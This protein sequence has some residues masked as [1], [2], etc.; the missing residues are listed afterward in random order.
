MKK[1]IF[2]STMA[3]LLAVSVAGVMK[4]SAGSEHNVMGWLWGGGT[5]S[6][7]VE[8]W[9]GTHT[10]LGWISMNSANPN[11]S[12]PFN[13]GVNIFESGSY[14]DGYAWSSNI[15]WVDFAPQSH[16]T[17]GSPSSGQYKAASC[18][19]DSGTAGVLRSGDTLTGWARFVSIA[20]A[21][22]DGNSGGWKGWIKMSGT[23]DDGSPYGITINNAGDGFC[24]AGDLTTVEIGGENHCFAWSDELGWIDFS[25][26]SIVVPPPTNNLK[27]CAGS[28]NSESSP[29]TVL[30]MN[31]NSVRDDLRACYNTETECVD[32]S[33]TADVTGSATWE[34]SSSVI[35]LTYV[36]PNEELSAGEVSANSSENFSVGYLTGTVN[37]TVNVVNIPD[38][39]CGDG[40]INKADEECDDGGG[41]DNCSTTEASCSD[42]SDGT[43]ECTLCSDDSPNW[44]EV[45]P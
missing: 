36:A 45:A 9:D 4:A 38:P 42:G 14:A 23:A 11:Q 39:V 5:E 24:K 28:C 31:E 25:G 40:A 10:N 30:N 15:G 41:N 6:D 1:K 37:V 17:T 7:G 12:S 8:P 18:T 29:I 33:G 22:A 2:L 20:K 16:C 34:T 3:F 44:R 27:V 26:A 32:L 13:Y 21:S 35:D 43:P 19:L